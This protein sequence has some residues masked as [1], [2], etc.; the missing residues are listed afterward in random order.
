[1]Q[2]KMFFYWIGDLLVKMLNSKEKTQIK[3]MPFE[4]YFFILINLKLH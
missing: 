1:M 3:S 2:Y 4:I